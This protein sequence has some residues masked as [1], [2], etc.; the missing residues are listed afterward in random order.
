MNCLEMNKF[1]WHNP[2]ILNLKSNYYIII[3][4]FI[5]KIYVNINK[6]NVWIK[7]YGLEFHNLGMK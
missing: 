5:Q 4:F 6:M 3:I 1:D 7:S 2:E